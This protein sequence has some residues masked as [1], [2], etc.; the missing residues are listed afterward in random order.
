MSLLDSVFVRSMNAAFFKGPTIYTYSGPE[1]LR[2][3]IAQLEA[4]AE[5][6]DELLFLVSSAIVSSSG[7]CNPNVERLFNIYAEKLELE[8]L[9]EMPDGFDA[10][11]WI[12]KK[13]SAMKDSIKAPKQYRE[14]GRD[15]NGNRS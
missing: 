10:E 8:W 4:K 3:Q 11:G 7:H 13:Y 15:S 5:L 14:L 9:K 12:D 1:D 2:E 6:C